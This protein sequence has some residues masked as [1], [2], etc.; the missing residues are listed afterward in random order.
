MDEKLKQLNKLLGA[1][2][3]NAMSSDEI[4]KGFKSIIKH[5]EDNKELTKKELDLIRK[6]YKD[7]LKERDDSQKDYDADFEALKAQVMSVVDA[8]LKTIKNGENYVLKEKDKSEIA[9]MI[10]VPVVEKIIEKNEVIR[11][12]QVVSDEIV[13]LE[14]KIENLTKLT[15][16]LRNRG[17]GGTSAIGVAQTFKYIAH[18]EA[19][20][21]DLDGV[22][23]TYTVK[24][25]IFWVAGF[26]LNG[27]QIAQL[28]N[29]TVAGRT[30]TFSSPIPAAYSGKDFE[31]KYIGH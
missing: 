23:T 13:R 15:D 16:E 7:M 20:V 1:F 5:V 10:D 3:T 21:G 28:P 12:R 6:A 8:K 26:T 14:K 4:T 9:S 25:T 17:S 27:E 19:P 29:F 30:I 18:T 31:C 22:N 2:D 11:E 24:N